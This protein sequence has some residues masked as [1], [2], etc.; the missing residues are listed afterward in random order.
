M[1]NA[2]TSKELSAWVM[3]LSA[4]VISGWVAW[5]AS[6][7]LPA[8]VSEAAW[9]VLWAIG[10]SIVLNIIAV[11]IGTIAVSIARREEMKD[12]RADERDRAINDRSMRNAYFVLSIG[13][14]GVLFWQAFGL[15]AVLAPYALFGISML[16]GL[17]FAV[18]QIVYYRIS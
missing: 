6:R 16:A 12:E 15:D 14:L 18:S 4:V 17:S 9:K 7:G 5:E 3:A 11:I 10:A 1:G 2:M 13:L 8:S